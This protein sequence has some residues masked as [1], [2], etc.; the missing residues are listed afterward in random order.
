M[1]A[2]GT[3]SQS[4]APAGL[5]A[6]DQAASLLAAIVTWSSDAIV[7]KTLDG[8]ITSWNSAASLPFGYSGSEMIGQSIRI[9]IPTDRQGEEDGILSRIAAG[10]RVDNYETVRLSNLASGEDRLALS[11]RTRRA[12]RIAGGVPVRRIRS[13]YATANQSWWR[14]ESM[15]TCECLSPCGSGR[16]VTNFPFRQISG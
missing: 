2:H 14:R 12:A 1:N 13:H 6:I 8:T 10:E 16:C 11:W 15:S 9:L 4:G 3:S 7:S 5:L